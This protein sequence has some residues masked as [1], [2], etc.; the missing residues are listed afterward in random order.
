MAGYTLLGFKWAMT[1][2]PLRILD[3]RDSPWVDGPGR[4]I[5]QSA[6]MADESRCEIIIGAFNSAGNSGNAYL[7]EALDRKLEVVP[8]LERSAF[9]RNVLNQISDAIQR[10]SIDIVH[11]HDFRSDIFGLWCAK[12]ARV[13]VVSTCHGWIANNL[14]GRIYTA[15]DRFSLRFFD[16]VITVSEKMR[17]QLTGYGVSEKKIKVIQNALIIDQY[18]PNK[19]DQSFREEL[20]I[21]AETRIIAN[22]GRLSPEKGQEIF[23]YAARELLQSEDNLCFLLIGIG[24][25]QDFLESLVKNLGIS[26][27][28]KFVGYRS[29]MNRIYNSLDLVVQSSITEG[30]PN[31]ILE[32]LL[33]KVPVVATDV[34]GTS[35]VVQHEFSGTLIEP[36]NLDM[37]VNAIKHWYE[38][39]KLHLEMVDRGRQYVSEYFDHNLRV[40]RLMELYD[41]VA[42]AKKGID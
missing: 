39:E 12:K 24:P 8:I 30:M 31:V 23:L 10:M 42:A 29:D 2:R 21:A 40:E 36:N 27:H 11:T 5:L 25:Q 20:G 16:R 34:G 35:E 41:Q 28:V 33:M 15:I 6:S 37:L 1:S 22:I 4:T 17:G 19:G 7:Q 38:N 3:L 14:K 32:S 9:D 26:D 18:E 13:P